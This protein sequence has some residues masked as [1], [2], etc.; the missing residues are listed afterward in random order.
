M[1]DPRAVL[2]YEIYPQLDALGIDGVD[3]LLGAFSNIEAEA[4]EVADK[5]FEAYGQLPGEGDMADFAESARDQ[6]IEYYMTLARLKQGVTNLLA[7]GLF[8]LFEQHINRIV[9]LLPSRGQQL[10]D[11]K[12]FESWPKVRELELL[13]NSVKHADGRS[14]KEL[15]QMRPDYFVD[16][17][18]RGSPLEV[19]MAR[20]PRPLASP[21]GGTD[22]FV[23][24]TD[25]DAYRDALRQFWEEFTPHL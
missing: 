2:L 16:P 3:R 7:V 14:A 13:A 19:M 21:I 11:Y 12:R 9:S 22:F 15:R 6:G 5:A 1:N 8:H 10:P 17:L 24:R 23:E 4:D 18:L 25:L 20:H